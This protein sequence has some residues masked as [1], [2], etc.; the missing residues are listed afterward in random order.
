MRIKLDFKVLGYILIRDE[1]NLFKYIQIQKKNLNEHCDCNEIILG[2]FCLTKHILKKHIFLFLPTN[3]TFHFVYLLE[4]KLNTIFLIVTF[5]RM[6]KKDSSL[7]FVPI[8]FHCIYTEIFYF[9]FHNFF[10]C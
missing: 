8:I 2:I 3:E 4:S 6:L 10:I 7:S 5:F 9:I 1:K